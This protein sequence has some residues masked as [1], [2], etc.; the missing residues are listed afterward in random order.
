MELLMKQPFIII[1]TRNRGLFGILCSFKLKQPS[2]RCTYS[3]NRILEYIYRQPVGYR[4]SLQWHL[5][6]SVSWWQSAPARRPQKGSMWQCQQPS[7]AWPGFL[8]RG[9]RRAP[10]GGPVPGSPGAT[11]SQVS[12]WA[13][14]YY[15][16]ACLTWPLPHAVNSCF[17]R[18]TE[19]PHEQP[20]FFCSL[21]CT[22]YKSL[23]WPRSGLHPPVSYL[24]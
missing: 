9:L 17:T 8:G 11:R 6:L 14:D 1:I 12:R 5:N 23:L 13:C 2:L 3:I 15:F 19:T 16:Q 4:W 22:W 10:Y 21:L 20:F 7:A 24:G 18:F